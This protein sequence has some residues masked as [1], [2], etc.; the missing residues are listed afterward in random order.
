[1]D[2]ST[3]ALLTGVVRHGLTLIAGYLAARGLTVDDSTAQVI[4]AGVVA[5][6]GVGWSALHKKGVVSV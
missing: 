3:K 4:A 1:M 2:D 6:I 5:V